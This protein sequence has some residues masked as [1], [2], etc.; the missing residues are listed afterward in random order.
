MQ[1]NYSIGWTNPIASFRQE[2]IKLPY[3]ESQL[4]ATMYSS[5][6]T[7]CWKSEHFILT[8]VET[9]RNSILPNF[10]NLSPP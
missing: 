5:I 2:A 9:L 4:N 10:V 1:Q 7:C 8:K 3:F 6:A